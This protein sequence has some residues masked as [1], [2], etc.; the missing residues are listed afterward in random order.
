MQFT[1]A[2]GAGT[3]ADLFLSGSG[4][5]ATRLAASGACTSLS[6][7][8]GAGVPLM[9]AGG[10][11]G[12]ITVW[13]LEQRSLVSTMRDAHDAP[14]S[15]IHFFAGEPVLLSA[16]GDNAL[17]EW[18]FDGPDGAPRLLRFR[19]GHAAPPTVVRHYGDGL[20]LLSGGQDRAFRCFSTIQDAQSR[21]MSQNHTQKRAKRL[22]ITEQELK[23]GRIIALDACDVRERDWANVLTAHEKDPAAYVWRLQKYAL[24]EHLLLPPPKELLH[25]PPPAPVTSVALSCCGNFGFVGSA[26]GRVDR[27]N[28]QSGIHRGVY[29]RKNATPVAHT[30]HSPAIPAHDGAVTGL[31][32]DSCNRYLISCGLDATLRVWNFSGKRTLIGELS[33]GAPVLKLTHHPSTG[34]A[35]AVCDDLII[36]MYD[37]EALRAVRRFKGHTDRITD[38]QMGADCRWL[39]S[40]SMDNTV[41]VWDVPG[42]LLAVCVLLGVYKLNIHNMY[43]AMMVC[44]VRR[45][46]E[47]HQGS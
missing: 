11:A 6:F 8:T 14:I 42:R 1:N 43:R 24:G 41:R 12:V 15:R 7:R 32:S 13:N 25:A 26:A 4:A 22:K 16:G 18:I 10:A 27:Y 21:E 20:R 33:T 34:L 46:V 36:R 40:S 45:N 9:A 31:A 17:K 3:N 38:V 23:L 2:A 47:P 5:R 30:P 29:C 39:L 44:L 28:M 35:A 37:V 19:S